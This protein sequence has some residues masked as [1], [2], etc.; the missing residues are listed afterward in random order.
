MSD[1][2][3]KSTIKELLDIAEKDG[4]ISSEE[5]ELLE[6][7]RVDADS[8]AVH[9]AEAKS[10]GIITAE[11]EERL[12][13]L[14]QQILDRAEIVAKIDGHLS[15]DEKALLTTLKNFIKTRYK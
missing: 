3:F 10:D 5:F 6:Q 14:K 11:E 2:L 15:D 13:K 9:L 7:V 1:D 12:S 8:Y 4:V